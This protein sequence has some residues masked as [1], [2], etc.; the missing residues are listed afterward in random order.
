MVAHLTQYLAQHGQLILPNIG[1]LQ[2]EKEEANWV[3]AVLIAPKE[4]IVFDQSSI[5]PVQSFYQ[6]LSEQMSISIDQAKVQYQ[7]FLAHI[8]N[9]ENA[10]LSIGNFGTLSK[11]LD[12]YS[13]MSGY[14]AQVFY[15]N[16][17]INPHAM[18]EATNEKP[19]DKWYWWAIL[20]A[21]V[22][23]LAI[24]FKFISFE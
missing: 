2:L 10:Q 24:L 4:K 12:N 6:F 13:W 11:Q 18:V 23:I 17:D 8:F 19:K 7:E 14:D 20:F 3:N 16:I 9:A 15:K 5:E 1:V 21:A 22:G